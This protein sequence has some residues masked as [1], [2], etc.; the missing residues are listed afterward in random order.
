MRKWMGGRKTAKR[1][2]GKL[3]LIIA[4]SAIAV[5]LAGLLISGHGGSCLLGLP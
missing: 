5:G 1:S 2:K 3:F 4:L